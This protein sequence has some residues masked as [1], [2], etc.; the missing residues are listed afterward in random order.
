MNL[1]GSEPGEAAGTATGAGIDQRARGRLP[2]V[3]EA[4]ALRRWAARRR[5]EL[6]RE[7]A[8]RQAWHPAQ[9][10]ALPALW[11]LGVAPGRGGKAGEVHDFEALH[12]FRDACAGPTDSSNWLVPQRLLVGPL[13]EGPARVVTGGQFEAGAQ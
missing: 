4:R 7:A 2:T 6:A 9:G 8:V 13:P 3:D 1:G 12:R 5:K 11:P 10:V